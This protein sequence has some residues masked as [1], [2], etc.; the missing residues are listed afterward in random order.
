MDDLAADDEKKPFEAEGQQD[1][2]A[3][4]D[5]DEQLMLDQG[6]GRVWLVKVPKYLMERWSS[7]EAED[8]H[9][10]TI[11]VYQ[12]AVGPTGK[13]PRIV[14]F[15]P[16]QNPEDPAALNPNRPV[17]ASNATAYNTSA[18]GSEPHPDSYELDMVNDAVDNQIV[19][20]E[21]P[22]EMGGG[23]VNTRARTTILTGRIK[24]ECNLRPVYSASYRAQM[25]QRS[26]KYNTPQRQI[27][28]I[29]DAGV[30]GGRG[31]IN[32]LS[33]GV[34]VGVGSAFGD[35]I[36]SKQKPGKGAFE[37]MARMPRNQL[38]DLIFSL[39]RETPRWGIKPLREKTQQPEA[40][41]KEVLSEVAWLHRS[42]EFNGMWELKEN[43]KEEGVKGEN[44]P[45]SSGLGGEDM[46]MDEDEDDDD[47]DDEDMEEVS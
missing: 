41:L 2:D 47:D 45:S 40:Y 17:F 27:M 11:R 14:L 39:F 28:M 21:R 20:A 36:K 33:S 22:K 6:N 16:P 38:L 9:L 4:P 29:E 5:P 42:G 43:F 24:H 15:L 3:Q 31:G 18:P 12:D 26:Q 32:R 25:K 46:K 34:G 13:K 10:A 19:V 1:D 35:L 8:V 37:R 23:P 7:I 44:V 30:S